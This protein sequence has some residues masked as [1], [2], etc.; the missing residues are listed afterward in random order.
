MN[1]PSVDSYL[2]DVVEQAK[3]DGYTKTLFGRRRYIPELIAQNAAVKAFGKRVAMNA[4][5]Q[6]AA[7][8]IMKLAMINVHGRLV[9]EGLDARIVMQVHD[10]LIIEVKDE[11]TDICKRIVKEEMQNVIE[12]SVP[13]TVDV[14]SGKNW[15]EQY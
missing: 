15:L 13:L 12:L 9:R 7:A 8:D 14:T 4:P 10:E 1:Y 3:A 11:Q 2:I 5:I 6:G